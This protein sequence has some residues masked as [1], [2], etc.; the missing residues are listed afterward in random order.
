MAEA[1]FQN[2][3]VLTESSEKDSKNG[4]VLNDI[5]EEMEQTEHYH[6]SDLALDSGISDK[7]SQ[8]TDIAHQPS[9]SINMPDLSYVRTKMLARVALSDAHFKHQ[10]RGEPDLNLEEKIEIAQKILDS[11]KVTFLSKFWNHLELEDL[12]YFMDSKDVYEI[13]FYMKQVMKN[14]NK[15]FQ[16]NIVKNRRY[17]A[18]KELIS[19]GEYFSDE[20][21]KFREPYLYEQMVGQYLT[22]KEIQGQVDKTDLTFSSILLKHIDQLDENVR[23]GQSKDKE[24]CKLQQNEC[25][26]LIFKINLM[27]IHVHV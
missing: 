20:E 25:L 26:K 16:K 3:R 17:E 9:S 19:K 24:V 14:K 4:D 22:Q 2:K 15:S 23:F 18:M 21:M 11:N 13:D 10:Q 5:S 27:H 1:C 12:E 6:Q 7:S 8:Q